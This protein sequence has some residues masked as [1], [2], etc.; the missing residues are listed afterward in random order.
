MQSIDFKK[1]AQNYATS[2]TLSHQRAN[3]SSVTQKSIKQV[4]S[5]QNSVKAKP[6]YKN[7]F[8]HIKQETNRQ[9]HTAANLD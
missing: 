3:E 2:S 6:R 8:N 1:A 4:E 5:V 7:I 9:N